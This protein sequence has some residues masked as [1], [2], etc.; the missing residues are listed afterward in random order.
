MAKTNKLLWY[1]RTEA[2]A[3]S[4]QEFLNQIIFAYRVLIAASL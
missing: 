3:E 1:F 4:N 2:E